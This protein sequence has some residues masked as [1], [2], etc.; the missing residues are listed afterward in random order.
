MCAVCTKPSSF[1]VRAVNA[2]LQP[3]KPTRFTKN[4]T[5]VGLA[6]HALNVETCTRLR[7]IMSST[8]RRTPVIYLMS[9]PFATSDLP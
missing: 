8:C 4:T 9:A 5:I 7:A 3:R 1:A 6:S 2:P